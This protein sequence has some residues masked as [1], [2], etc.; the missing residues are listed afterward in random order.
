MTKTQIAVLEWLAKNQFADSC[1]MMAFTLAFGIVPKVVGERSHPQGLGG[2]AQ[3]LE[4]LEAA[5]GLRKKLPARAGLSREW[6]R[7]VAA[8]PQLEETYAA[9][10]DLTKWKRPEQGTTHALIK[11][12][13]A[14]K[15][16]RRRAA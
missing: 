6:K 11:A 16:P 10:E 15:R 9:E 3:C 2:F 1:R 4:L 8:W 7:L 5:P 12:F 13:L 14:G